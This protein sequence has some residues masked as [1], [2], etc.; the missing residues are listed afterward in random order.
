MAK[1]KG[2]KGALIS[3]VVS[4]ALSCSMFVGTTFAW[5]TDSVSSAENTI[6]AGNLDIELEYWKDGKWVDVKGQ[7]DVVTYDL[8][9]PGVTEVAYMRVANAGSL[10]LKYQLGVNIVS[11]TAGKN[12]AGA[13]FLLSD[14]IQFGVVEDVNGETNAYA[15][16]EAAVEAVTDAK[17]ISAKDSG[18]PTP[19]TGTERPALQL[20]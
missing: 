19:C 20:S 15:N 18:I 2:L 1:K 13:D 12:V 14:Y 8:W 6:I 11:E 10:A 5:F 7:S 16:R 9:E 4:I 17:K 3:S